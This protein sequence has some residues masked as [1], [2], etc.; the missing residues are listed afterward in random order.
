MDCLFDSVA[1]WPSTSD[2]TVAMTKVKKGSIGTGVTCTETSCH[3]TN[4]QEADMLQD[5][6]SLLLSE[7]FDVKR[8]QRKDGEP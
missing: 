1:M 7:P 3:S 4:R 8:T 5:D 2:N 6:A